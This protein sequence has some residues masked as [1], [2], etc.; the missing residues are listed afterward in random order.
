MP[1]LEIGFSGKCDVDA[2][3]KLHLRPDDPCAASLRK[4]VHESPMTY[5]PHHLPF[6]NQKRF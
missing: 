6:G 1:S 2:S 3:K 4:R 5:A